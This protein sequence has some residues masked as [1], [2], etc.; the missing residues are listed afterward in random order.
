MKMDML[1]TIIPKS[2]QLNSD[3]LIGKTMVIK[4]TKVSA[5]SAEQPINIHFE[6]DSNKPYKPSKGMRRALVICWGPD[7]SKYVGRSIKLYRD[8]KVR[9]GA[10]DVGGIRISHL[11]HIVAKNTFALT[12]SKTSRKPYTIEPLMVD[13]DAETIRLKEEG[14]A[15]ATMG[16][17]S[18]TNWGKALKP[19]QRAKIEGYISFWMATAKDVD[20]KKLAEPQAEGEAK[21]AN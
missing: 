8:E 19:E 21:D 16:V 14:Q 7:A 1:K 10:S 20:A 9:F 6:G 12:M 17:E 2:D 4:I 3:D 15:V 5:G 13:E 11:S 18:Y